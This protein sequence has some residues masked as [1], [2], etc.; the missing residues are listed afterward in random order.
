MKPGFGALNWVILLIYLGGMLGVGIY[1][2]KRSG[3]DTDSFF[4]AGGKIPAWA[5]G[6]SIFATTLSSITFMSVP[7]QA[8]NTDWAY[9]IGSL[10]IIPIIPLLNRFYVPFFRKLKVTTAYEYL[11]ARFNTVLRTLSSLL[12]VIYHIGRIAVVTYLPVLAIASV[13]SVNPLLIAAIVGVLC[14]IYTFLGGIEGVVWSDVIQAF[15]LIG[16]ALLIIFIGAFSIEGNFGTV[17]ADATANS[18]FLSAAD[19][20]PSNLAL[21]VPLIFVGQFANSLFQYT[22]SQDVVQR[23]Q[24]TKSLRDTIKSLWTT[25]ALGVLT[26]PVFFGM[27]T[28]LYSFYQHAGELPADFNTSALIPYFVITELPAGIAGFVIAG[29]FAA[30]QSTIASSLNAISACVV[31]DFRQRFFAHKQHRLTDVAFARLT[32]IVA[33]LLGT[34]VAIYF[35]AG[36]TSSTWNVFLTVSG[37]FGVP[38]A[39]LFFLGIFTKRANTPG[40]LIG[41]IAAIVISLWVN[42]MAISSLLVATVAFIAAIVLGY[43]A[44]LFFPGATKNIRGLTIHTINEEYKK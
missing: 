30:A 7:E 17:V 3:K 15:V 29:I 5:A 33:G 44:S 37:L 40:V 25:G 36:N 20:D 39:A 24:T 9:A 2:S 34:G 1:F 11:E 43:V 42:S 35:T 31:T 4:K 13:T 19:F 38:V 14:I 16:G 32:I 26:I 21:F 8:F 18:K 10:V 22:G 27:G 23:Y 41:F 28:I 12:F 6:F